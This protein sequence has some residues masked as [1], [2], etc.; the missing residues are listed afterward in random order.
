M[1]PMSDSS[2]PQ[3]ASLSRPIRIRA[4]SQLAKSKSV[5]PREDR[6]LCPDFLKSVFVVHYF[7]LTYFHMTETYVVNMLA[8]RFA[9]A[10]PGIIALSPNAQHRGSGADIFPIKKYRRTK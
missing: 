2:E 6:S 4:A 3:V 1:L 8:K 9:P 5:F 7:H 10:T